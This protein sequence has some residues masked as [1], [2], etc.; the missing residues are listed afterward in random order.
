MNTGRVEG[1]VC[2]VTG[3]GSGLGRADTVRLAAEGA[4]VITTDVDMKGAEETARLAGNTNVEV[5]QQDVVDEERWAEIIAD[6][7]E[8]YG[9]LN[10]LVNNAGI[11]IPGTVETVATADWRKQQQIMSDGVFFGMKYAIPAMAKNG[12]RCSIINMSSTCLLYTSPR[13]RD[14]RQSRMP[15]SA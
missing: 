1:K 15:S 8:R 3:G 11:V 7:V 12:E 9:K 10:V 4:T 14:K 2:L 13:P 5:L 6:I